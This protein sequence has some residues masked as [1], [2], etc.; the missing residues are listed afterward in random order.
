METK[1]TQQQINQVIKELEKRG[2]KNVRW[3]ELISGFSFY[4]PSEVRL[5]TEL[6]YDAF[7]QEFV[8]TTV[9]SHWSV[10]QAKVFQQQLAKAIEDCEALNKL[11][12]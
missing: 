6:A 3:S 4:T 10:E 12:R 8:V 2:Y 11:I 9:S 5:W 7:R 1:L